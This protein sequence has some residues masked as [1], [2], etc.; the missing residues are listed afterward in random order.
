M[1][2]WP[3]YTMSKALQV[4]KNKTLLKSYPN[5]KDATFRKKQNC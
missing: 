2:K 5:K 1:K 4:C 3:F